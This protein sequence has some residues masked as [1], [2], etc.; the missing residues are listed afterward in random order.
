M[1]VKISR[2]APLWN[3]RDNAMLWKEYTSVPENEFAVIALFMFPVESCR[4]WLSW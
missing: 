4:S 2:S 3:R 1:T